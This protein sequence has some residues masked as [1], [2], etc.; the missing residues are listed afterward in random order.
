MPAF[1][2]LQERL[3]DARAALAQISDTEQVDMTM[4]GAAYG[5][6][7]P[8]EQ[9]GLNEFEP[10]RILISWKVAKPFVYLW[11]RF[12]L[13]IREAACALVTGHVVEFDGEDEGEPGYVYAHCKHCGKNF[14]SH[15]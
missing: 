11:I 15:W 14:S 1:H 8:F 9:T 10:R 12:G 6:N 3:S 2:T 7:F 13:P 5:W 4:F